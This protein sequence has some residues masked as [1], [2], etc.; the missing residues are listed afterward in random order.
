[1]KQAV[2]RLIVSLFGA[3]AVAAA[4]GAANSPARA[5]SYLRADVPRITQQMYKFMMEW[6]LGAGL[7]QQREIGTP[8]ENRYL[9]MAK[10]KSLAVCVDWSASTPDKPVVRAYGLWQGARSQM[11]ARDQA[12]A[13]CRDFQKG[14]GNCDCTPLD[15]NWS[16][17]LVLPDRFVKAHF[18]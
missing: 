10:N 17:I 15:D 9:Q 16:S 2:R 5:Q 18:R 12:M 13:K 4:F 14:R 8:A 11:S 3:A 1:M 7:R 6:A